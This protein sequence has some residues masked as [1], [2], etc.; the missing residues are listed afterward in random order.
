MRFSRKF[1]IDMNSIIG[2][3]A[4][5]QYFCENSLIWFEKIHGNAELPYYVGLNS[6]KTDPNVPEEERIFWVKT[7]KM[8]QSNIEAIKYDNRYES[9]Q[10]YH[11]VGLGYSE[12]F[13]DLISAKK[14]LLKKRD[15]YYSTNFNGG[16]FDF[17]QVLKTS[18]GI[19]IKPLEKLADL[20]TNA[21]IRVHSPSGT[22]EIV[23]KEELDSYLKK[24][25]EII[26]QK[27][28]NLWN[29]YQKIKDID[30]GFTALE[31]MFTP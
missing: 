28:S 29:V 27:D 5:G 19:I 6:V 4:W 1:M 10:E 17:A 18:D 8:L 16:Y 25:V 3:M 15:S 14:S 12:I 31:I 9:L 22:T 26:K 30:D 24:E 7:V 13:T 21:M 11:S 20:E 23:K 2:P